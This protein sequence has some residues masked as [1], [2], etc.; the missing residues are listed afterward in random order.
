M[1]AT[2]MHMNIWFHLL[3]RTLQPK[4]GY[5]HPSSLSETPERTPLEYN[6]PPVDRNPFLNCK[7]AENNSND[8]VLSFYSNTGLDR[9]QNLIHIQVQ[10]SPM[11]CVSNMA[12]NI[13]TT[14]F[15]IKVC[16][17]RWNRK[18]IE[19]SIYTRI[20]SNIC[21]VR[22]TNRPVFDLLWHF[23]RHFIAQ[24][25]ENSWA[26]NKRNHRCWVSEGELHNCTTCASIFSG[27]SDSFEMLLTGTKRCVL[28]SYPRTPRR[29]LKNL[30]FV[31]LGIYSN[32]FSCLI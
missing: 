15:S 27:N 4:L 26:K 29:L 17:S 13:K 2:M 25:V 28:S 20:L 6:V 32:C 5:D 23:C 22:T 11:H 12:Y 14:C 1:A 24:V 31:I 21:I 16:F 9:N 10:E 8:T 7:L 19:R 18:L 30:A 3:Q